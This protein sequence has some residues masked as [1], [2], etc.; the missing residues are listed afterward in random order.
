MAGTEDHLFLWKEVRADLLLAEELN[1][2]YGRFECNGG[3][4]TL[5]IS[6]SGSSRQSSDDHVI[7]VM[8]DEVRR[9]LKRVNV[10]KA[11]GPDGITG[12]V[13]RS[14][15]DQL[16]GLFTSIFNESLATSVVPTSVH[17]TVMWPCSPHTHTLT[18]THDALHGKLSISQ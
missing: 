4:A 7:T 6:A 14:C 8:E 16:V 1:T 12:R 5:P 2:F 9:E 3:S 13:L 17:S 10:R 11:A 18:H 15:A